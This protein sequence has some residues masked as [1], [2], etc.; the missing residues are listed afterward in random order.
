[1]DDDL[2][3]LTSEQ[4][5]PPMLLHSKLLVKMAAVIAISAVIGVIFSGPRFAVG[6]LIGGLAS[7]ANYFWQRNS[8]R[9]IFE[10]AASGDKP[11]FVAVRYLLRYVAIGLFVAFFYF[12]SLLP[13]TA[14][15]LGLSA[16]A[17]AVVVVGIFSIF[18]SSNRQEL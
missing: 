3:P 6:V 5:T 16:F 15:I 17:L 2:D 1:M 13:V 8:T 14:I 9:A 12:T 7:F 4:P 11:G 10:V 18:T